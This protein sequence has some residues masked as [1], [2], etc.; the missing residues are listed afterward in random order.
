MV[1]GSQ[2]PGYPPTPPVGGATPVSTQI[3]LLLAKTPVLDGNALYGVSVGYNDL[4]F[5]V[6]QAGGQIPPLIS[7]AVAEA[8]V[9]QAAI[10]AATQG[11][12]IARG[13][14]ALHIVVLNLYDTGKSPAGLAN[15]TV[16]FSALDDALQLDADERACEGRPASHQRRHQQTVQRNDRRIRRHSDSAT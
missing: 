6:A 11:G 4:F 12:E 16:P 14:R 3:D 10:D 13:G 1:R 7:P 5:A 8:N 2:S 15:P 9:V